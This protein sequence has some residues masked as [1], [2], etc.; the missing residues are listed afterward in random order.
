MAKEVLYLKKYLLLFLGIYLT[1]GAFY[2]PQLP[3][4]VFAY[5]LIFILLAIVCFYYSYKD[6]KQNKKNKNYYY[7]PT[8]LYKI[9]N[10]NNINYNQEDDFYYVTKKFLSANELSF[11]RK[12][13]PLENKGY[14]I[15]PQVNLAS[16][17]EKRNAR[18]HAE[19]FRN[20][21]FGIFNNDFELL[22]L[23]ELNDQSHQ[24]IERRDRDLK[25]KKILMDC[26]IPLMTFYSSYPNENDY[27]LNRVLTAINNNNNN[28]QNTK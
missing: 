6:F 26:N 24:K 18:Y 10:Q 13:K 3:D 8:P 19:L 17:I 16:I 21:D 4:Y 25:V 27:V 12:L 2:A 1:F 14:V 22:L 9:N 23:I 7:V 11:Y 15:V 20:I 5:S 28:N